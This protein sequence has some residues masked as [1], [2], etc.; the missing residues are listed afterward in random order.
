MDLFDTHFT[1]KKRNFKLDD[2]D[3]FSQFKN[4]PNDEK[5]SKQT[6]E[7]NIFKS[8]K[9]FFDDSDEKELY[10][11]DNHIYF[12]TSVSDE[13]VQKLSEMI[14][15][16]NS[17][18]ESL[19]S[20][21]KTANMTPKPIYLH[22]TTHGGSLFAG[23]KAID[24]IENSNIPIYTVAEGYVIS[25][26]TLMFMAGKRKLMSRNAFILIHQISTGSEGTYESITDS[27]ENSTKFMNK[28]YDFYSTRTNGKLTKTSLREIMKRD[29]FWDYEQC[30][31]NNVADD[32]YMI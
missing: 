1:N 26:G 21:I 5:R 17:Q 14:Y 31:K 28:L 10:N 13:S 22:I 25:A 12:N 30:K 4:G 8:I 9:S 6:N 32:V 7:P 3:S 29:I 20:E 16:M 18:F 27:F 24:I 15:D 19:V 23:F 2:E 11:V